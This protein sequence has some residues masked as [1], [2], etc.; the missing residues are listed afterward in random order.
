M[1]VGAVRKV[2]EYSYFSWQS[3]RQE[4]ADTFLTLALFFRGKTIQDFVIYASS[5]GRM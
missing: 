1:I 2:T 4:A 5:G 3:K